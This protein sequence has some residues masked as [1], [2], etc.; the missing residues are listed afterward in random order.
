MQTV[1]VA[2]REHAKNGQEVLLPL[3]ESKFLLGARR[4]INLTRCDGL[5]QFRVVRATLAGLASLEGQVVCD[6]ENPAA[7]IVPWTA[8]L[9]MAE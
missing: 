8:E 3:A 2:Q 4:R 9:Q 1:L 5:I 6:A 7:K